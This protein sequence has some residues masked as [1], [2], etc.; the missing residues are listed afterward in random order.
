TKKFA[1]TT[2]IQTFRL[3]QDDPVL[4]CSWVADWKQQSVLLKIGLYTDTNATT[5]TSDQMYC[6]Q[7]CS[8]LPETPADKARFEKIMH[9]YVDVST[10]NNEW[11]VAFLNEG[12][13]AYD[14]SGG[15]L[16]ISLH[17]SPKYP[18]PAAEAWVNR[19]RSERKKDKKGR[20]PKY[21]GLGPQSARF[22]VLPHSGGALSTSKGTPSSIVYKKAEEFNHPI[23]V[24]PILKLD[25]PQESQK[26]I[27]S[28]KLAPEPTANAFILPH[29]IKLSVFKPEEWEGEISQTQE[30]RE[31]ILRFVEFCGYA[32][33]KVAIQFPS[34]LENRVFN[35]GEVDLLERALQNLTLDWHEATQ[36][37]NTSFG[38]FE[39]KSFK[40]QL[41]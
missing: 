33:E 25:A 28:I 21:S 13:Y 36:T 12:K 3:F 15:R 40:I 22:G 29:N 31:Y 20:P 16:R 23:L 10:P 11:G 41:K 1:G 17:R 9:Q 8:T 34:I 39:I 2:Q 38:P 32:T 5:V 30:N 14:A 19:E 24:S 7:S 4:Y 27:K 6:A 18:R 35:I 37:L 26:P